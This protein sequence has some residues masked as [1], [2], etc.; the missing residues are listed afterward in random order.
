MQAAQTVGFLHE[1][2]ESA[3]AWDTQRAALPTGFD[4]LATD[5]FGFD[6]E[7]DGAVVFSLVGAAEAVLE[8]IERHGAGRVH[9]CGLLLVAMS[10]LQVALD[11]PQRVRSLTL[12][13]GQ[14]KP[15]R[16]LAAGIRGAELR[17][18]PG[19]GH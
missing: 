19:A 3:D 7:P 9:L 1:M 13:A 15:P 12:A 4:A 16:A 17:I 14:V 10:A 11:H 6:D 8:Q 2:G 5:V 18:I